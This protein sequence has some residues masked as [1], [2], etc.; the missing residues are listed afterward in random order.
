MLLVPKKSFLISIMILSLSVAQS[1]ENESAH[2]LGN[3]NVPFFKADSYHPNVQPPN[4]FLGFVLGSRPVH[5]YE[6]ID[7][8]NY[9]ALFLIIYLSTK[10]F[11]SFSA[12]STTITQFALCKEKLGKFFNKCT[13]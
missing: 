4:E 9:S 5:H 3:Y 10:Y 2:G 7:Y 8:F 13:W 6:V 12:K 11:F 1:Y